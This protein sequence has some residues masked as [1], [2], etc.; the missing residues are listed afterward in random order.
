[1]LKIA[2]SKGL[3]QSL[4]KCMIVPDEQLP[5]PSDTYDLIIVV[6]ALSIGHLS[7]DV[8][9]ELLM[10]TKPGAY[11]CLAVKD[12]GDGSYKQHLLRV[13]EELENKGLWTKVVTRRFD[14]W[15]KIVL[16]TE[17]SSEYNQG[18]LAIYRKCGTLI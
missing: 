10:I 7:P 12:E 11:V 4:R 8:L 5:T 18:G 2:E 15:Q 9:P 17:I 16:K 3:Y 1:M 14:Q 13:T 6:G